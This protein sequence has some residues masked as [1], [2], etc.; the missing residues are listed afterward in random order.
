MFRSLHLF[1]IENLVCIKLRLTK[2]ATVSILVQEENPLIAIMECGSIPYTST[3]WRLSR[4]IL[5]DKLNFF[6]L[7]W[8]VSLENINY[9]TMGVIQ[10]SL[11]CVKNYANLCI[12]TN[13]RV[14]CIDSGQM[15][16]VLFLFWF[17]IFIS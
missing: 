16:L 1:L 7:T 2:N 10:I 3:Y 11:C 5:Q 12:Y 15:V 4:S 17:I 8:K 13:A 14:Y 6:V 9:G